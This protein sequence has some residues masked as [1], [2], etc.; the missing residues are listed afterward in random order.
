MNARLAATAHATTEWE[1]ARQNCIYGSDRQEF[2]GREAGG[3]HHH[4]DFP[5]LDPAVGLPVFPVQPESLDDVGERQ[6]PGKGR[7]LPL[8]GALCAEPAM[9]LREPPLQL[10]DTLQP[11][12][13]PQLAEGQAV[14]GPVFQ[15]I[16][17]RKGVQ[18][19][20]GRS[21]DG[22]QQARIP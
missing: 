7:D 1:E 6:I 4:V 11:D 19:V 3:E 8:Q 2:I 21:Q 18:A 15:G 17:C 20:Q 14:S 9:I 22:F 5:M 12:R 16:V 13:Q 10:C